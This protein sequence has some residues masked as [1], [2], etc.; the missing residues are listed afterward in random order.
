MPVITDNICKQRLTTKLSSYEACQCNCIASSGKFSKFIFYFCMSNFSKIAEGAKDF[1][2]G[3][4]RTVPR[5]VIPVISDIQQFYW[6]GFCGDPPRDPANL[7]PPPARPFSGGQC[8][9]TSYNVVYKFTYTDGRPDEIVTDPL[10]YQGTIL[11]L[12]TREFLLE[13]GATRVEVYLRFRKCDGRTLEQLQVAD[14]K[15]RTIN[16]SIVSVYPAYGGPDDCGDPPKEY[17]EVPAPPPGGYNSAPY[18]II[19]NN[20]NQINVNFNFPSPLPPPVGFEPPPIVVNYLDV[21][22]NL[23]IPISFNF[24]GDI[25]FGGGSSGGDGNFN[26][27]DRDVINNIKNVTSDTNNI[28]NNT[29]NNVDNFYSDYKKERD[30]EDNKPPLPTDFDP[31]RPAVLPGKYDQE[32][33]AFVNVDLTLIPRNAKTQSGGG[34]PNVIYAGWFEFTRQGKSFPRNYIHFANNCFVAPTGADGYAFT[35]YNGYQGNAIAVT[36]KE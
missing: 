17:P 14:N 18:P 1:A 11:G 2:C 34:A 16:I 4:Y 36:N 28:T 24:N 33:L 13:N 10:V 31:P 9:G 7:P 23:K 20:G 25:N 21:N 29:N 22:L 30:K 3:L 8:C 5:N 35:L 27:D 32:R 6:D 26:Q 12:Q 19:I 15:P